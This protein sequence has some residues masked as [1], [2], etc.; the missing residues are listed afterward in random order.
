MISPA[1]S[2]EGIDAAFFTFDLAYKRLNDSFDSFS[3]LLSTN[4]GITYD[5]VLFS[6]TGDELGDND[7]NGQDLPT[8]DAD[9]EN[10]TLD[11]SDYSGIADLKLALLG[12]NGNA[13]T[14]FVDDIEFFI[15]EPV[16]AENGTIFSNP[17]V[18]GFFRLTFN[19]PADERVELRIIDM[20]GR[21]MLKTSFDGVLNQTYT[22]DVSYMK[23]GVY[24]IQVE[25]ETFSFAKRLLHAIF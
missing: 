7:F 1:F 23:Q 20:T 2:L 15:N 8:S 22:F 16:V 18:D 19:R 24:I 3:V 12:V 5:E 11:L 9:W 6:R 4:C 25:G 13:G 10:I 21:V 17:T 14:L